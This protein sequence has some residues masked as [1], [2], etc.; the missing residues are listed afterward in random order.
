MKKPKPAAKEKAA[1]SE[2]YELTPKERAALTA[3]IAKT[4]EVALPPR[5][6]VNGI[7][8]S[9]DHPDP[10]V[11]GRLLAHALGTTNIDFLNGR[12]T[13]LVSVCSCGGGVDERLLNY[14]LATVASVRPQDEVEALLAAQMAA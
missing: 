11:G 4:K 9:P 8:I 14:M 12:L 2:R 3:Y 13:E 5:L 7:V 6:K 1:I 10:E